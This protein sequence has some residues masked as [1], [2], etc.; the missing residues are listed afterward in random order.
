LAFFHAVIIQRK[1][2][3]SLGWNIR[4][5]FNN[6]DVVTSQMMLKNFLNDNDDLPWDSLLFM[7][8]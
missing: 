5:E 6:S 3:G 4:Y 8:G 7:T 2:F 1:K